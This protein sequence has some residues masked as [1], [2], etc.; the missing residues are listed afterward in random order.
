M[1]I[2]TL[3]LLNPGPAYGSLELAEEQLA[4]ARRSFNQ[5]PTPA[6]SNSIRRLEK[7]VSRLRRARTKKNP[8]KLT[9]VQQAVREIDRSRTKAKFGTSAHIPGLRYKAEGIDAVGHKI[10]SRTHTLSAANQSRAARK[11][12]K[13][14]V[15]DTATGR[16]MTVLKPKRQH[17]RTKAPKTFLVPKAGKKSSKRRKR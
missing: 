11:A 1:P 9:R 12:V 5:F 13:G 15:T 2:K 4:R 16:V 14:A 8:P 6:L 10:V 17:S 3:P 7:E